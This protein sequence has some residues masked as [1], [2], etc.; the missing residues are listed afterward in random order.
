MQIKTKYDPPPIP[1]RDHDWSAYDY[2]TYD[3]GMPVGY[4]ATEQEA[5]D[6][7][8]EQLAEREE[9]EQECCSSTKHV[10]TFLS[11]GWRK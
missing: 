11:N 5:I 9:E 7:L 4:G 3:E 1:L 10:T 6:D 2:D 8:K